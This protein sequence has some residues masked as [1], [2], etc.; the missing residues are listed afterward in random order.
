MSGFFTSSDKIKVGQTEVSIPSENGL[1]YNPG[2]RI[3]LYIPPTSKFVDLSQSKL[4]LD[5]ELSIPTVNNTNGAQRLQLDAQTG[6]HSLIRSIR[7]FSGRKTALLEEIEGYD[8]LTALRFDY[9]T[10][11]SHK[12]KRALSE[13]A[14]TYDPACRGTLGTTKTDQG[15][16]FSN[17]YFTKQAQN[18]TLST[19]FST[20][21]TTYDYHKAKGELHL[22]TGLFRNEAVFPSL[23]TDGIFVEILLQDAKKVFRSLDSTNRYR[24]LRLNPVYHS[25]NGS[26]TTRA[27]SGSF[28]AV[29]ASANASSDVFFFTQ[30]NNQTSVATFP[31]VVGE[32]VTFVSGDNASV[33]GSI[34]RITQI[35]HVEGAAF[36]ISKTKITLSS[37]IQNTTGETW[38]GAGAP[39]K[40]YHL[41]S[42]NA[43]SG[44]ISDYPASYVVSN[45]EMIV[46]Q[47][48]VPDGYEQSMISM[49]KEGG[50]INYDYRSFTNYRY[51]QLQ[52]DNV[53]NIR[54]PLIESRATSILCVP[55]DATQYSTKQ[56]LSAS[57]T[58]LI[59]EDPEDLNNRSQR[60]AI[61]GIVD[62]LQEYQFIYDQ[63]INP[64]RQVDTSKIAQK[65]S[66][67]QYWTIEAEKALAMA[68]ME[69][70]SFMSF[71][72]NFF[73]GRALALGKNAVYDARGK[74]FNLQVSYTS[75][76]YPQTK[77]KLWNNF[78]S[79]LRRLEIKNGSLMVQV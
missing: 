38:T 55:T 34:A 53:A 45:V 47:I 64:N 67:S 17:P 58:Y 78:V 2:G 11:E 20:T 61:T 51:S 68:D 41:M 40:Q 25:I 21:D 10:N 23:L 79:H 49:M 37:K 35:E 44:D 16:C 48:S 15:N 27:T 7:V 30:D 43:D 56:L 76:T 59:N 71:Q 36:G 8:I 29:S 73:I 5:V 4:K 24:R 13:G 1:N 28:A 70:M 66:I 63:K 50:T 12:S 57:S 14:T 72:D 46:R 60:S 33:N 54:L 52:G 69:P 18:T 65:N 32:K 31:F 9:E 39:G 42:F 77:P 6:L 22:N 74:D 62:G 19:S 75:S 26:D 3:E